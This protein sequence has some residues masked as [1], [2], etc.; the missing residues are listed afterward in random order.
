MTTVETAPRNR[1]P[2]LALFVANAISMIGN[3]FAAIS[4]PWFVLQTTGSA[5]QTGITGFFTIL[6][7]VVAAFFGGSLVDRLGYKRT[8]IIADVTSGIAIAIIPLLYFT[9]GLQFW[10]LL[11]LVFLGN[12]LDAPGNT[13]RAAL[14]PDLANLA[15]MRM[16]RASATTQAIERGSRL[17]GAPLVGVLIAIIGPSSVLWIDAGTFLFSAALVAIVVPRLSVTASAEKPKRYFDGL[18]DGAKFIWNDRLL[19]AIIFAVMVTNFL[20]APSSAVILPVFAKEQFGSS[21]DLGFM[22]AAVGGGAVLGAILFG[23]IGHKFPRRATFIIM[24]IITGIRFWV[25]AAFPSLPV[26]LITLVI[27]GFA[28]GPLNPIISTIAYERIP[29]DMRGRVFGTITA[30][31]YLAMPL[32]VLMAGFILEQIGIL[33]SL[34]ALGAAYLI[35]TGSL[36]FDPALREM[37]R[38]SLPDSTAK[39]VA[40]AE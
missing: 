1:A 29:A 40:V 22:F 27:V 24:F 32:G 38:V 25:L 3:V 21:V 30:G 36:A 16:E 23:A 33:W 11:A 35:A 13:A 26:I 17:I 6:P 37:D 10:Q 39:I 14:V 18:L 5:V 2:I 7:V 28:A 15:R 19:R 34:L 20:D 4:I 9:I 8:S 12:L 31:A